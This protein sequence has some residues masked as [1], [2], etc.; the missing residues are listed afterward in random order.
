VYLV[1]ITFMQHTHVDVPHFEAA[2]WTWLRGALSTIDRSLGDFVDAK[3]HHIASSHVVHH[4][5]S[6]MPFYGAVEATP[7]VRAHL[8]EFYKSAISK[9]VL[10]SVYLGYWRDFYYNMRDSIAVAKEQGSEFVWFH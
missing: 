8:G 9:P 6:E 5:F 10:A 3:L 2:E 1:S 7:Y 4:L